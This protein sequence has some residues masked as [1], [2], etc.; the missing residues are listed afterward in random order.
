VKTLERSGRAW[1][2]CDFSARW[3]AAAQAELNVCPES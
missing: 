3:V 1:I 2:A